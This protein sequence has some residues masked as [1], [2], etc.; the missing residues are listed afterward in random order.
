L[1]NMHFHTG[2]IDQEGG[3]LVIVVNA[4]KVTHVVHLSHVRSYNRGPALGGHSPVLC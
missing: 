4:V 2:R 1:I 3:I